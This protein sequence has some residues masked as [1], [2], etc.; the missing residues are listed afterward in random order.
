MDRFLSAS[1]LGNSLKVRLA[2]LANV[3]QWREY[4][5]FRGPAGVEIF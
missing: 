4:F 1:M 2:F 5:F 3:N